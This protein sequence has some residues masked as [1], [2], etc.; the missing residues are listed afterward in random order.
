MIPTHTQAQKE[1]FERHGYKWIRLFG[2][3]YLVRNY[4]V[5][6]KKFSLYSFAILQK[7]K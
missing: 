3:V 1:R 7:E 5:R 6:A 4:S 2:R